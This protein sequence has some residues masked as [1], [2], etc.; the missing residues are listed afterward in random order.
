[1]P[2]NA[3]SNT[4]GSQP[5]PSTTANGFLQQNQALLN[6][7]NPGQQ[8]AGV[9]AGGQASGIAQSGLSM[10]QLMQE[11]GLVDQQT[12]LTNQYATQQ[13]EQG[14]SGVGIAQG[15]NALAEQGA[16]AQYGQT[17][18]QQGFT[19]AEYNLSSQ[20]YPEQ[21]AQA[22]QQ[23]KE[24]VFNQ[25]AQAA[26]SGTGF[27]QGTK[28]AE[29]NQALQYGW[30]QQDINRNAGLAA[31]G[32]QAGLSATQ[33]SLGDIARSEQ[34]LQLTAAANG[35]SVE[36]LKSQYANQVGQTNTGAE[37]DLTQ[38]YTQYLSQQGQQVGDIGAAGAQLGLL[39]PGQITST[40]QNAG[41][42][43]SSLF[44]GNLNG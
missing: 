26:A 34:N 22:A 33:Y 35:L 7:S 38:L 29:Q 12:G 25:N 31:L 2:Y 6:S 30:Q 37:A 3:T 28:Q 40:G 36:Q 42:N 20:Q 27:T 19:T 4:A 44:S 9:I 21:L 17:Q 24:A 32:Q 10:A 16:A 5:Q 8:A 43:L 15:Q 41:L 18:A 13:L 39:S 11:I 14:L 1:M 23:N